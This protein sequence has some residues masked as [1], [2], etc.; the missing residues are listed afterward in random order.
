[1]RGLGGEC[2]NVRLLPNTLL[3]D[4]VQWN[5]SRAGRRHA[6]A[7]HKSRHAENVQNRLVHAVCRQRAETLE[8]VF[9]FKLE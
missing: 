8:V 3:Q 7:R 1:M 5:L 2:V 9:A 6:I 4:V